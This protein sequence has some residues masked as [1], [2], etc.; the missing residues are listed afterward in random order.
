MHIS[1]SHPIFLPFSK[2]TFLNNDPAP[3]PPFHFQTAVWPSP[4]SSNW[5][6]SHCCC[7]WA[8]SSQIS[9][10]HSH[11]P[12]LDFSRAGDTGDSHFLGPLP[13][14]HQST[15][16]MALSQCPRP[17]PL[18]YIL[19]SLLEHLLILQALSHD[20]LHWQTFKIVFPSPTYLL[21]FILS[22]CLHD[23]PPGCPTD[24]WTL[25]DWTWV[26]RIAT[27]LRMFP[28]HHL[29]PFLPFFLITYSV[30]WI[31][32]TSNS[33]TPLPLLTANV[34]VDSVCDSLLTGLLHGLVT[35]LLISCS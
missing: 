33:N 22:N 3:L 11:F 24:A 19:S 7:H 26:N 17:W 2:A 14:Q 6:G 18:T 29:P 25:I 31:P 9:G 13:T 10:I 30:L 12:P 32:P 8:V 1:R 21:N 27:I 23:F 28:T 4:S 16:L 20:F 35:S 34:L 15:F 5:N